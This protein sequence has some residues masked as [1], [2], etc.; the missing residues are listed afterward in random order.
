[1]KNNWKKVRLGD[2]LDFVNDKIRIGEV[3]LDNYISTENLLPNKSGVVRAETL[4]NISKINHFQKGDILFSNIRTYFKK[5]WF[6]GFEGGA[7]NDVLI[8]RPLDESVLDKKFLYYVISNDDFIDSTVVSSKGTKMPRGDKDAMKDFEF[9]LPPVEDQKKIASILSAYD[10]LIENN[11]RRIKILEEMAQAIY[12]EWFV[13]FKFPE[14]KKVKM[15]EGEFGLMPEGWEIKK[16]GDSILNFDSKRKPISKMQRS[17]IGGIYPYYGAAKKID[18]V[19][20]YIFDGK[21]LLIAEDGSVIT[22]D[23]K[24]VLQFIKE[25]FWV[26]NHTHIL[27]GKLISTEYLYLH[28]SQVDISGYITGVA[29]PKINQENLNRIQ[30]LIPD[31]RI[32]EKFDKI[33]VPIFEQIWNFENKNNNIRKTRDLLLP[34]LMGGLNLDL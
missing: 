25:K 16:I 22:N 28:L 7:S 10:D 11:S 3:N 30:I 1:M 19:N 15:V 14:Y 26:N 31:N 20:D 23:N 9:L 33:A 24:P 34:K 13:E 12:K 29:Q 5:V 21:Y 18:F 17:L 32:G 27:Q 8:F 4:P 6:S 2:V